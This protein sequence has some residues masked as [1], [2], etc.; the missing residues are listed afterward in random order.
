MLQVQVLGVCTQQ[1]G[2]GYSMSPNNLNFTVEDFLLYERANQVVSAAEADFKHALDYTSV[3]DLLADG[4]TWSLEQCRRARTLLLNVRPNRF[5]MAKPDEPVPVLSLDQ[6]RRT[7]VYWRDLTL[8]EELR[9]AVSDGSAYVYAGNLFIDVVC[10]QEGE[11]TPAELRGAFHLVIGNREW[12][13]DDLLTME[14]E[15][16]A[17]GLGEGLF[18][19]PMPDP[20]RFA[21]LPKR[22]LDAAIDAAVLVVQDYLGVMDGGSTE[23]VH[24][25]EV[26]CTGAP[27][28]EEFDDLLNTYVQAEATDHKETYGPV[29]LELLEKLAEFAVPKNDDDWGSPRQV[30][31]ENFFCEAA[32]LFG[33]EAEDLDT[34]KKHVADRVH[35][36]MNRARALPNA[37]VK[38]VEWAQ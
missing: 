22:V 26:F 27:C 15:L 8:H 3:V 32:E 13:S 25:S 24:A 20:G 17:F 34:S 6:F 5:T 4:T 33:V 7:R 9:H 29:T 36:T 10:D 12:L 11:N 19:P 14:R 31:A 37:M 21:E 2:W 18:R 28:R 16:Y 38:V 1:K 30:A 35:I 23:G